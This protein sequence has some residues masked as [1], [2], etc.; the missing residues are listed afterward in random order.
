MKK[1]NNSF[2]SN[3]VSDCKMSRICKNS[4]NL[5]CYVCG[6]L[7]LS[8][9]RQT[10]TSRIKD[11]YQLYF[12]FPIDERDKNW[13]P[14]ICCN[15]CSRNLRGW[16]KGSRKSLPFMK[17]VIWSEPQN[18]ETDCYFC[19]TK[20]RGFTKKNKNKVIYSNTSSVKRPVPLTSNYLPPLP[21]TNVEEDRL[22][23]RTEFSYAT[24]GSSTQSFESP[25]RK[26]YFPNQTDLNNFARDLGLSKIKSEFLAS[27]FKQWNLVQKDVKVSYFR[28]RE[29]AFLSYFTKDDD[30]VFCNNAYGLLRQ[31]CFCDKSEEWRLFI[32]SSK[33]SL[34][35]V[36]LH[37]GNKFP[38]VPL[39]YARN[40]KESY[41]NM[42]MILE[43]I[44]YTHYS[45][46]ICADLKVVAMLTGLQSGYTK[47]C[48]FLCEWDSRAKEKHYNV[49]IWPTRVNF[50]PGEKNISEEPLIQKEKIFL[51][52]LHIKLGLMKNFVKAM[53]KDGEGFLYIKGKFPR[54][55]DAKVKEGIFVGPQI[56]ELMKDAVFRTKLNDVEERAWTAFVN[57]CH[58]F[59]GNRKAENYH[60]IV[61]ELLSAYKALKCNMSLKIHFLDSHLDFFPENLGAVSDEHGERFHQD[62]LHIEKRYNGNPSEGMLADFCWSI[63]RETPSDNPSTST[64]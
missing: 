31:L 8:S 57:V 61:E 47:F 13:L 51:P 29:Q 16:L 18:H 44:K 6:N 48:C 40:M 60:E 28:H 7:T 54:I 49:K 52:P 21:P 2:V 9:Q 11:A 45:W 35:A 36:L 32:D 27:K 10:I 30:L 23:A 20:I 17:P 50:I 64:M 25:T 24:M 12:G 38:S 43:K 22:S 1:R 63:W 33:T 56:R 42:K 62:M 58:S 39:A 53:N 15:S 59:L 34:K 3:F 4:P 19:M 37:N 55:S 5:F 14:K 46:N 26:P 41:Q